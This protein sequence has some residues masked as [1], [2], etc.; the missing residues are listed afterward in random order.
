MKKHKSN[1]F[2]IIGVLACVLLIFCGVGVGKYVLTAYDDI[3][4]SAEAVDTGEKV[5]VE[6]KYQ[7]YTGLEA[8]YGTDVKYTDASGSTYTT[9]TSIT[10]GTSALYNALSSFMSAHCS[11]YTFDDICAKGTYYFVDSATS[12]KYYTLNVTT[13]IATSTNSCTGETS[14]SGVY[15]LSYVSY[16]LVYATEM[17]NSGAVQN[18][19]TISKG[20][21]LT[22]KYVLSILT[23]TDNDYY[24]IGL[25]EEVSGSPSSTFYSYGD[26]ITSDTTFY[27]VF[28]KAQDSSSTFA[29]GSITDTV[30]SATSSTSIYLSSGSS[31]TD[32]SLDYTYSSSLKS[33]ALGT[34]DGS[35][36]I[37][38]GATI[39]FCLAGGTTST[40]VEYGTSATSNGN[41]V[42]PAD[43]NRLYTVVLQCD[44][45]INGKL[46]IGGTYGSGAN[47]GIQ[48]VINSNYVVLDLNGHSI[49]VN[50]GG[51]I[52]SYGMIID[53][54]GTGS[55]NMEG[56]S[57]LQ[58][59][60]VIYDY[61]GGTSASTSANKGICPFLQYAVPYLRCD[62]Y[63]KYSNST[64]PSVIGLCR[65]HPASRLITETDVEL[66]I[67]ATSDS[68]FVLG[69][70][71]SDDA[72]V[73]MEYVEIEGIRDD[74]SSN[75]TQ[76]QYVSRYCLDMRT[77]LVFK[78]CEVAMSSVTISIYVSIDTDE[79]NFPLSSF[80]DIYLYSSTFSFG[81]QVQLMPGLTL[82][83]DEES[84]LIFKSGA[85][86]SILDRGISYYYKPT[87]AL[88]TTLNVV[89]MSSS[90][91]P[92]WSSKYMWKYLSTASVEVYGQ[93]LFTSGSSSTYKFE[94]PCKFNEDNVGII[95]SSGNIS[96]YGDNKGS[97]TDPFSYL[98][99]NSVSI[100]TYGYDFI[101]GIYDDILNLVGFA[102]P[103]VSYDNKA[104]AVSSS[105]SYIGTYDFS[106]GIF[107]VDDSTYFFY[108][109][110][111]AAMETATVTVAEC[112][113]NDSDHTITYSESTYAYFAGIF[114]PYSSGTADMTVLTDDSDYTSLSISYKNT[115]WTR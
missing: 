37:A 25:A 4:S 92:L 76:L 69:T 70:A 110:T 28:N 65:L 29:T 49:T 101:P 105:N 14:Y 93:I 114:V 84:T 95:D 24:F 44:M 21:S 41:Y 82:F 56:G 98:N 57:T 115:Y 45:T 72:Y 55:I 22:E 43:K 20:S 108:V 75:T 83:A 62:I 26:E 3:S 64:W 111:S 112:E 11:I 74:A 68:L 100:Q 99:G 46:S 53:S 31:S 54:V 88:V 51:S 89:N 10:T 38:S 40:G 90:T 96:L 27:A 86:L 6:F 16:T 107:T 102:R 113:V 36:T 104:Y 85:E 15:T 35:V 18:S 39:N 71:N 91:F 73:K 103:L 47:T 52:Y 42:E 61:K 1:I 97:Y 33:V 34:K 7:M 2:R 23:L 5:T 63:L 109:S 94:G 80:F 67:L 12:D 19:I 8:E 79:V 87:N 60:M 48:G 77:K 59:L 13:K 17:Y 106:T 50:S 9:E 78:D 30:N 58:T 32:V 66:D 81:Q